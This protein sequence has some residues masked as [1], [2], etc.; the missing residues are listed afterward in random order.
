MEASASKVKRNEKDPQLGARI[1]ALRTGF[2]W[3]PKE[4]CE[5]TGLTSARLKA[6]EA[7]ADPKLSEIIV[8]AGAFEYTP[9]GLVQRLTR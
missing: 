1:N 7:G 6:L 4:V 9:Q 2:N 8:L 5:K 3:N